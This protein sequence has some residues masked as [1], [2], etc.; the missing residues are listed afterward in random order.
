M[1]L[2]T[3]YILPRDMETFEGGSRFDYAV[4]G[5]ALMGA[6]ESLFLLLIAP[7]GESSVVHL[8]ISAVRTGQVTIWKGAAEKR[9]KG[10]LHA[11]LVIVACRREHA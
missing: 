8:Y 3:R 2:G 9:V 5:T 11:N 10:N 6:C 7:P 4:D 1:T